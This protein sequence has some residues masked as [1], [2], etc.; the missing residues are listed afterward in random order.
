MRKKKQLSVDFSLFCY[1]LEKSHN[2][3][4]KKIQLNSI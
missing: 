1:Q 2:Y 3:K 4:L